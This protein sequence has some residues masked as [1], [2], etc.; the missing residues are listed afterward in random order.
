MMVKKTETVIRKPLVDLYGMSG[1]QVDVWTS[2]FTATLQTRS[3]VGRYW[4][5]YRGPIIS[6]G[7]HRGQSILYK[8]EPTFAVFLVIFAAVAHMNTVL[9]TEA[10]L[11]GRLVG[12]VMFGSPAGD[13][14]SGTAKVGRGAARLGRGHQPNGHH[15]DDRERDK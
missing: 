2:F 12:R 5:G 7:P 10:W 13:V 6:P 1:L 3:V 14:F 15:K 8:M 4:L 11:A 9:V